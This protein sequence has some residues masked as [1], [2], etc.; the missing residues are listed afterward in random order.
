MPFDWDEANVAHIARHAVSP[1]EAEQVLSDPARIASQSYSKGGELRAAV[2][3]LTYDERLLT[4]I[5]TMR[6]AKR[7]RVVTARLASKREREQYQEAE[8]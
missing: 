6:P 5:V 3:G 2:T 4:V 8:G 7:L 1:A